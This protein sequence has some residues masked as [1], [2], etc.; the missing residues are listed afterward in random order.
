M[1]WKNFMYAAPYKFG[2]RSSDLFPNKEISH[3]VRRSRSFT[4]Q[5]LK[6]SLN[7]AIETKI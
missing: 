3:C 7:V 1:L 4:K 2:T 6:S 5:E